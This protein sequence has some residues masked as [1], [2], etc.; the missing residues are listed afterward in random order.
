M[1]QA[2]V[3]FDSMKLELDKAFLQSIPKP[4]PGL[5]AYGS[6]ETDDEGAA[7]AGQEAHVDQNLEELAANGLSM[8]P[9]PPPSDGDCQ[10]L[11]PFLDF[12]PRVPSQMCDTLEEALAS[13]MF[14]EFDADPEDMY[15][16]SSQIEKPDENEEN[17]EITVE[18]DMFG[19]IISVSDEKM[20]V[21]DHESK[22]PAETGACDSIQLA[23]SF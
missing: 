22:A 2:T 4:V 6:Q 9:L 10:A 13:F 14:E 18:I 3:Q 20:E 5:E 11:V 1:L 12:K 15:I 21:V 19:N 17:L 7:E 23:A 16:P 8:L